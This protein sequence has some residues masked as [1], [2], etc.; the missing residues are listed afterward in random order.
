MGILTREKVVF[1]SSSDRNV[2]LT[3]MLQPFVMLPQA[4]KMQELTASQ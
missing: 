4:A 3:R 2:L 1:I